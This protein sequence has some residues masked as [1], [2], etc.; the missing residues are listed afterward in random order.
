[1]EP[2]MPELEK[3][4]FYNYLNRSKYFFEFGSGGSTYQAAINRNT[5]KIWSVESDKEW[6]NQLSNINLYGKVNFIFADIKASGNWG[7][8][9]TESKYEDW[10]K[11]NRAFNNLD[12]SD[13]QLVDTILIDG[14]FRVACALNILEY[15]DSNVNVVFDDFLDRNYYHFVLNYYEIIDQ[16]GR[17]VVLK[18]KN[19]D[20]PHPEVIKLYE[21]D[22]R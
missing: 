20:K 1:M 21:S 12:E 8:P 4:L 17:M 11:Y 22:S 18:K 3:S 5:I 6:L 16:A 15:I 10:V 7:Y 14:R 13:R 19:V 9:G 2:H